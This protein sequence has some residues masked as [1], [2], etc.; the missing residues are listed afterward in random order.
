MLITVIEE[1]PHNE[2]F[3]HQVSDCYERDVHKYEKPFTYLKV[4]TLPDSTGYCS[5][6]DDCSLLLTSHL[7]TIYSLAVASTFIQM[8]RNEYIAYIN[9]DVIIILLY[10]ST[11]MN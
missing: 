9:Y 3:L 8:K 11:F 7:I 1:K 6:Q 2:Y 5:G 10:L 4:I